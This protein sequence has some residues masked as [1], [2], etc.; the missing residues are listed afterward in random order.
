MTLHLR[1]PTTA[2]KTIQ[3]EMQLQTEKQSGKDTSQKR[4]I[5]TNLLSIPPYKE[6]NTFYECC[7]KENTSNK[8]QQ[9]RALKSLQTS[10]YFL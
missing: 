6:G 5:T 10:K 3:D 7:Q 2:L 9:E 8:C 1:R 4:R